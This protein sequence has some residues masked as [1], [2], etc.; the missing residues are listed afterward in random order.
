MIWLMAS[1]RSFSTLRA[2][3]YSGLSATRPGISMSS[4]FL[5]TWRLSRGGM[6]L[7]TEARPVPATV[8]CVP[9]TSAKSPSFRA[10]ATKPLPK[11]RKAV[12][13]SPCQS[14]PFM[15]SSSS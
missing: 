2:A 14:T 1:W 5:R 9:A 7:R 13:D 12:P 11:A 15:L 10:W 3:W 8:I 4:G 6:A